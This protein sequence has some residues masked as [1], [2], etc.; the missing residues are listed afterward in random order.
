MEASVY[1]S[2]ALLADKN[3]A[4]ARSELDRALGKSE[5]LGLLLVQARIHYLLGTA[6]KTSGSATESNAQFK[7]ALNLLERIQKEPGAE[8]ISERSDLKPMF[9][10]STQVAQ[11]K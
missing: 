7:S 10:A 11:T 1:L 5:K 2:E 6:L 3:I 8:H 4:G 9:E